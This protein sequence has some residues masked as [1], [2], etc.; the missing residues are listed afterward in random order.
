MKCVIS[1]NRT[2][3][4]WVRERDGVSIIRRELPLLS[5]EGALGGDGW[6]EGYADRV[7]NEWE[8]FQE[9]LLEAVTCKQRAGWVEWERNGKA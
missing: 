6:A 5:C 3:R 9:G 7:E 8:C 2:H 4:C 1:P